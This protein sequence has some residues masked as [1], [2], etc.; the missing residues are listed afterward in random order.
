MQA[1][2]RSEAVKTNYYALVVSILTTC[3]PETAFEKLQSDKPSC[4]HNQITDEDYTDMLKMRKEGL[5]LREIG[6]IYCMDP[7]IVH[8]YLKKFGKRGA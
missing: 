4:V 3:I 2:S 6:E 8:R 7:P 1:L 5:F